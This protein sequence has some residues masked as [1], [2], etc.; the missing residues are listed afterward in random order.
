MAV[1][2]SFRTAVAYARSVM[3]DAL[4]RPIYEAVAKEKKIPVF[5]LAIGDYF[6]PPIVHLI[7]L[8]N[9][10]GKIGDKI[11]FSASDDVQVMSARV[12]IR[13]PNGTLVEQGVAVEVNKEW[14]YTATTALAVGAAVKIHVFAKD[15]PGHEGELEKAYP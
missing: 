11:R 5:A 10:H 12:E 3:A 7:D 8:D 15:R 9:Y 4:R 2:N 6:K 1:R 13:L 14:F